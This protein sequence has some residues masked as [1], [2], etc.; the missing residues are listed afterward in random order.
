MRD[1]RPPNRYDRAEILLARADHRCRRSECADSRDGAR[2]RQD[3]SPAPQRQADRS[4]GPLPK[5]YRADSQ[6]PVDRE[7][8]GAVAR[9]IAA[10]LLR[11]SMGGAVEERAVRQVHAESAWSLLCWRL[12][13]LADRV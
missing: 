12:V 1:L 10:R 7:T 9:T 11:A 8:R 4:V 3:F 5:G 13:R 6:V 2:A